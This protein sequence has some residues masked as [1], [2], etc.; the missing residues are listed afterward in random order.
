MRKRISM[1][2]LLVAALSGGVATPATAGTYQDWR[3]RDGQICYQDRGS[4][5]WDGTVVTAKW[6]AGGVNLVTKDAC[7]GYARGMII[8]VKYFNDPKDLACGKT[9]A[10]SW[11][12]EYT[13]STGKVARWVPNDMTIWIN[14]APSMQAGCASTSGK[15]AH[16]LTHE[17][18]HALG[19]AHLPAGSKSVM[20]SGSWA[21]WWPTA[22]DLKN[23]NALY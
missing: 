21:V 9:G 20:P 12:W 13:R 4:T 19:L 16:V 1:F 6:R 17:M 15:R 5:R 8:D 11:S 2:M 22:L 3:F 14:T 10:S 18:G 23:L 7:T